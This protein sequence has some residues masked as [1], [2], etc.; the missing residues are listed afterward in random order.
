M[1]GS[2]L[3]VSF[4]MERLWRA[5]TLDG[6]PV[7]EASEP[8]VEERAQLHELIDSHSSLPIENVPEPLFVDADASRQFRNADALFLARGFQGRQDTAF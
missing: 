8:K 5:Q 1:M 2:F 4:I 6:L 7:N 3:R